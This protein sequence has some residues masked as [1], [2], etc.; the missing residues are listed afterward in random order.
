MLYNGRENCVTKCLIQTIQK[1]TSNKQN[2]DFKNL[3]LKS[4]Y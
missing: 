4:S 2:K 3:V 1:L